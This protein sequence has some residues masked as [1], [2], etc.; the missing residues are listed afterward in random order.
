M[1]GDRQGVFCGDNWMQ[2]DICSGDDSEI[3][4]NDVAPSH[5]GGAQSFSFLDMM[6]ISRT[7]V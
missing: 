5:S 2:E 1:V 7:E 3:S 4:C 6:K